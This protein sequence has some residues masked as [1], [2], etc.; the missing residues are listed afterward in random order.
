VSERVDIAQGA[1]P[2]SVDHI[3][4]PWEPG[5]EGAEMKPLFSHASVIYAKP[6]RGM[7]RAKRR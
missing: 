5:P 7:V 2:R 6:K 4:E 3:G 1:V